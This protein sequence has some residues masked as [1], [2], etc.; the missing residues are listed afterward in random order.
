[1]RRTF[2]LNLALV[3][4]LN[5]LVKPFYIFGIDAEVQVLALSARMPRA[6]GWPEQCGLYW[7]QPRPADE[8]K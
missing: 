5:L 8:N 6:A 4:V 3:L 7:V 2:L 1:M